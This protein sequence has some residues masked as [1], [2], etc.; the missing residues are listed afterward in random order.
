MS[1]VRLVLS[2][3]GVVI[4]AA[5]AFLVLSLGGT[6]SAPLPTGGVFDGRDFVASRVTGFKLLPG[7]APTL[8]F[9]DG[10][11]LATAGGCNDT[12]GGY[13]VRGD[14]LETLQ[15]GTTVVGCNGAKEVQDRWMINLLDGAQVVGRGDSLELRSGQT[16]VVFV[17][18]R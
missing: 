16:R 5:V 10:Q 18:V 13:A 14:R 15:V 6:T 7:T 11:F 1:R 9:K 12:V 4:A 8:S 17:P 3:F 2:G